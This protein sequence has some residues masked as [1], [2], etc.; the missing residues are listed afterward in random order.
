MFFFFGRKRESS[1]EENKT[2]KAYTNG[3]WT[4]NLSRDD[5]AGIN[6]C[7]TYKYLKVLNLSFDKKK[8]MILLFLTAA[9]RKH[10][11]RHV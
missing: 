6:L 2:W 8:K 1:Q 4:L 11:Q 3:I 9:Q 10:V 7:I 5:P